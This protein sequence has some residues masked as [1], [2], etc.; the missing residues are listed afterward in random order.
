MRFS[1]V[2][3]PEKLLV[4]Q[5]NGSLVVF[6]GAGISIP[7]G[8]CT[9]DE[10]ANLVGTEFG[11]TRYPRE[12]SDQY[13]GRIDENSNRA[14]KH[15]NEIFSDATKNPCDLH[16]FVADLFKSDD[17]IRIVT[18]NYDPLLTRVLDEKKRKYETFFAPSLP[19]G[20]GF[21]G[22]VYLHGA[23][24][25]NFSQ[26]VLTDADF[27]HAYITH[28]WA[29]TF[30]RD[31]FS[32]Y[33]V[34]FIGYSHTDPVMQYFARGLYKQN[35]KDRY[36]LTD[37]PNENWKLL[38]LTP[39][40]YNNDDRTYESQKIFLRSW[41]QFTQ[42]PMFDQQERL[43]RILLNDP[44]QSILDADDEDF[45]KHILSN[46]YKMVWFLRHA[47]LSW[48]HWLVKNKYTKNLFL[49]E[50]SLNVLEEALAYWIADNSI[51]S[52]E[53]ICLLD[54]I[55]ENKNVLNLKFSLSIVYSVYR[56]G[57][58]HFSI[59]E[60]IF[61]INL[62]LTESLEQGLEYWDQIIEKLEPTIDLVPCLLIFQKLIEPQLEMDTL[63]RTI[64]KSD[65]ERRFEIRFH[66]IRSLFEVWDKNKNA[67]FNKQYVDCY[68]AVLINALKMCYRLL[69]P[70]GLHDDFDR[71]SNKRPAIER[72]SQNFN[73]G[74]DTLNFILNAIADL[75]DWYAENDEV[76]TAEE[77]NL[78]SVAEGTLLNRVSF[79]LVLNS[80][81]WTP[82]QKFAWAVEGGHL[83]E[84]KFH[85]EAYRLLKNIY[86]SLSDTEKCK[87]LDIALVA[88]LPNDEDKKTQEYIKW[89]VNSRL[90]WLKSSAPDC[91]VLADY[92]KRLFPAG[93]QSRENSDFTS[94]L[95]PVRRI[96]S[97]SLYTA[98]E[99]LVTPIG[100]LV[101]GLLT[102]EK[103]VFDGPSQ[104]GVQQELEK[105]ITIKVQFSF[106]LAEVLKSK[107]IWDCYVWSAVFNGWQKNLKTEAEWNAAL[108]LIEAHE[109]IA[110]FADSLTYNI[111]K[112]VENATV[113][114]SCYFRVINVV[115]KLYEVCR[116][117]E[118]PNEEVTDW[119][120]R[121]V[122]SFA[123]NVIFI[124]L[125]ILSDGKAKSLSDDAKT[126]F[127]SV[128]AGDTITDRTGKC[129]LATQLHYLFFLSAD[130]TQKSM[131]PLFL[132]SNVDWLV[133]WQGYLQWGR[134]TRELVLEM[135]PYYKQLFSARNIS[136]I[137]DRAIEYFSNISLSGI[138]D[139]FENDLISSFLI[140]R[141]EHGAEAYAR[142]IS[143]GINEMK[144]EDKE[145]LWSKWLKR[146]LAIRFSATHA[147]LNKQ[148]Y[149]WLLSLCFKMES[150]IDSAVE[151]IL[152]NQPIQLESGMVF[153]E[154]AEVGLERK[155][156][157]S[158]VRFL[159]HFLPK[160][161]R[162]FY[163]RYIEPI[164]E[165]NIESADRD[166]KI[167]LTKVCDELIR[168]G[169]E[170]ANSFARTLRG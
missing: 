104:Y 95:G 130:W 12:T 135:L 63:A 29:S 48:I 111:L 164:I 30:L 18:T 19:L 133:V 117:T 137:E 105:A 25:R 127:D 22:L 53:T 27:G 1:G 158:F 153:H 93:L 128:V 37:A 43:K 51:K 118:N 150:N 154:I 112:A 169:S 41:S 71:L 167:E 50:S 134:L 122:N 32:T 75:T 121:S 20:T 115:K 89:V 76:R 98:E 14:K 168:L 149:G 80:K 83:F 56:Y 59:E 156:I 143:L 129:A 54:L 138:V 160:Q 116:P 21:Q 140:N 152:K 34:L 161:E 126:F 67:G 102:V 103:D 166:L 62:L 7:S 10:L 24:Q 101:D 8:F 155:Y 60:K 4:A 136:P 81:Y 46:E 157:R 72:H 65:T 2:D 44:S 144:L 82:T 123:G 69:Y 52:K 86:P 91:A 23:T 3:I 17:K 94:W 78:L 26:F 35:S 74:P 70:Q 47:S 106:E 79:N 96:E 85:H 110:E 45:I 11:F 55:A 131:F 73:H 38:K 57:I 64:V 148:E 39:I 9:Y 61:L 84:H 159:N 124:W 16:Y 36:I 68:Y 120:Q 170:K 88:H 97:K 165:A 42:S 113:P 132:P 28:G 90:A 119:L 107:K 99:I 142:W 58:S 147:P 49:K 100:D 5:E 77:I 15:S 109:A 66:K 146:Y 141:G 145:A 87:V 108:D 31:M 163:C 125:R 162:I 139:P 114:S 92:E 40:A 151:E 13:L 6:V 33:D